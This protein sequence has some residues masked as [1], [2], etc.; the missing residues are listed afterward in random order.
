MHGDDALAL[1]G[2]QHLARIELAVQ[3]NA[4]GMPELR[5]HHRQT[6]GMEHRHHHQHAAIGAHVHDRRLVLRQRQIATLGAGGALGPTS[7]ATGIDKVHDIFGGRS[8]GDAGGIGSGERRLIRLGPR[9]TLADA[10]EVLDRSELRAQR[11]D[12]FTV[13]VFKHQHTGRTVL[14][15]KLDFRRRQ[16]EVDRG[17][18][19]ACE[20]TSGIGIEVFAAVHRQDRYPILMA[21]AS[22]VQRR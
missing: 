7:G 3:H 16:P 13:L 6:A 4:A 11:T 9:R 2:A 22:R 12:Y 10:Q 1:D 18:D 15:D 14:Q 8:H 20:M 19:I 21:H 17:A 5:Q